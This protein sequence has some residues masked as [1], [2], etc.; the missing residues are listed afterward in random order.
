MGMGSYI[1][2]I[3]NAGDDDS[4]LIQAEC[5]ISNGLPSIVI[6]GLGGKAVDEAKERIRSAFAS[7]KLEI[8]RKKITINLAP[9]DVPKEGSSLDLAIATSILVASGRSSARLTENDAL[10]GEVGLDGTIRPVR[11]VIGKILGG[12][13]KNIKTFFIPSQN[14]QQAQLVPNVVLVPLESIEQLYLWLNKQLELPAIDTNQVARPLPSSTPSDFS[15]A[16]IAGQERAKRA[17]EI[18]A[19]GGHNVLLSGPPGTGK[20][21]LAKALVSILP[22]LDPGEILEVT[23]LH[24]LSS[25]NYDVLVTDR[26]FR[27]PHHS[28]S[29]VSIVGGGHTLRPGEISLSHR[30]VLFFDEFPEFNRSTIESLRQPLEERTITVSRI[31]GSAIY[32]ADFIFIATANPCPCGYFGTNKDC[33]CLP[34]QIVKYRNKLSG[35]I[36]DRIDLFASVDQVEYDQLLVANTDRARETQEITKRVLNARERQAARHGSV[37][38]LNASLENRDIYST[39]KL[40]TDAQNILTQAAKNMGISARGYMR[41]IKVARTIADLDNAESIQIDHITEALQYR[42]SDQDAIL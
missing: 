14:V 7:C 15:L 4:L 29:H 26:P 35:P 30:G 1:Q 25:S 41:I 36:I 28:A 18:A 17:L 9:A 8:P 21:M 19:A 10:I 16:D 24:S 39:S 6:V 32:P 5:R 42:R 40:S 11:G 3:L 23:H 13:K 31:K 34:G 37:S 20:S 38:K 2:T 22:K 27:A 33:R 12:K